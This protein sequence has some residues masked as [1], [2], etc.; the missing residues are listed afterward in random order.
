[1]PRKNI[2]ITGAA[3]GIGKET[4]RLFA[5]KDWFVGL[6]DIDEAGLKT[7]SDEL[8]EANACWHVLDVT[9]TQSVADAVAFFGEKTGQSM[10]VLFNNAG[11]IHAGDIDA[12][13]LAQHKQLIDVN[14]WGVIN[15]SVQALP[16]LKQTKGAAIV[17]MSSASALY[18]HPSLT[19]YAASKMAVR[20][21]TEG[22][23]LGLEKHGIRV[24]DVMPIWVKTNLAKNAAN[25]WQG[26]KNSDVKI[27][28]QAV[29]KR[30]WKAAHSKKLHWLMGAETYVY[31]FLGKIMPAAIT[32]RT[33]AI[34]TKD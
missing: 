3:A 6:F 19:S 23:D 26:L 24:S 10:H 16:L 12:I 28:P 1:M 21:I 17:N 22:M 11:I 34:I 20:S 2:F 13:S 8:G 14:V 30:V 31:S 7:L 25:E 27:T 18:G 32:R 9:D 29:A 33:A 15:C 5:A 4:A